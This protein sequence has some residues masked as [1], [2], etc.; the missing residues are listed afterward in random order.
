MITPSFE[1]TQNEEFVIL[2]M[3]IPFV[4][5]LFCWHPSFLLCAKISQADMYIL[6]AEFKFHCKP[7]FLR[8]HFPHSLVENGKETARYDADQGVLVP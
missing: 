1:L 2:K 7:Y 5:V 8:L 3:R 6:D 4:K